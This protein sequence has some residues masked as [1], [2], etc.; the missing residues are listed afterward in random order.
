[1]SHNYYISHIGS[2]RGWHGLYTTHAKNLGTR[3]LLHVLS[4]HVIHSSALTVLVV[5]EV[6]SGDGPVLGIAVNGSYLTLPAEVFANKNGP[7]SYMNALKREKVEVECIITLTRTCIV[8]VHQLAS[9]LKCMY[10]IWPCTT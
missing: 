6:V 5:Q 7:G 1:M 2:L 3:L 10:I 4:G 8:V 9:M